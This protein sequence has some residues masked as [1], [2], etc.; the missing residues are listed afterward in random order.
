MKLVQLIEYNKRKIFLQKLCRKWGRETNSS[1]FFIFEKCLI[2]GKSK[3]LQLSFNIVVS[4][5]FSIYFNLGYNKN[6]Q[7]KNLGPKIWSILI[8][9]ESVWDQFLHHILCM[10]FQESCFSCYI[11]STDQ[12]SQSVYLYISRY[13]AICALQLFLNQAVMS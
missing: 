6:K 1:P 10:S 11:L 12:I 9:Q 5:Y 13:W 2:P 3:R 7:Y 4:I 8:F